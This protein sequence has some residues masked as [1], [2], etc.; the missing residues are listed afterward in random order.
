[1]NR[2]LKAKLMQIGFTPYTAIN[3]EFPLGIFLSTLPA[4]QT[5]TDILVHYNGVRDFVV[6]FPH[7]TDG[8]WRVDFY[9]NT[10]SIKQKLNNIGKEAFIWT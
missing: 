5:D 4:A 9:G 2:D 1:M 3:I 7:L 8:K 10:E 6:V